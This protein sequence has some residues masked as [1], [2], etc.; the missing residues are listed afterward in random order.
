MTHLPE[1][2]KMKKK[3]GTKKP[4]P[5]VVETETTPAKR[6][7]I[8]TEVGYNLSRLDVLCFGVAN[9][10]NTNLIQNQKFL[11]SANT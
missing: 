7:F 11:P 8:Q 9:K 6:T 3:Y 4:R 2:M 5:P 10:R 1:V